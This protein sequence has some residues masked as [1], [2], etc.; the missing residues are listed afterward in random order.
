MLYLCLIIYDHPKSQLPTRLTWYSY[1]V[2]FGINLDLGISRRITS[3]KKKKKT[4]DL[5]ANS[6][7]FLHSSKRVRRKKGSFYW[8]KEGKKKGILELNNAAHKVMPPFLAFI[9][10]DKWW[11][12]K[13]ILVKVFANP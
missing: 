11:K 8:G 3:K 10:S 2:Y 13:C 9:R 1:D 4:H 5:W 6:R 12:I 7:F